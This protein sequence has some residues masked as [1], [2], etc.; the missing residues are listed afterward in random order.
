M[1]IGI[2]ALIAFVAFWVLI[3]CGVVVGELS[4]PAVAVFVLLWIVAR[5]GLPYLPFDAAASLF[6]PVEAILDIALVFII[7]EGDVRLT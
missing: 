7:F 1:L 6:V 5:V 2:A 4:W 3:V